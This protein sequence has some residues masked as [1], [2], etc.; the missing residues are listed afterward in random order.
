MSCTKLNTPGCYESWPFSS[1][2]YILRM[3]LFQL[4]SPLLDH[5][6]EGLTF[7][8]LLKQV[9]TH[10]HGFSFGYEKYCGRSNVIM[11]KN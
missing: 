4:L 1:G 6:S 8:A 7:S 10:V 3:P 9:A 5:F 2:A 11:F